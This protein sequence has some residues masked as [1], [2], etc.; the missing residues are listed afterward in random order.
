MPVEPPNPDLA[1]G[2]K[3]ESALYLVSCVSEKRTNAAPA[4]DLYQSDWFVKARA[5]VEAKGGRWF[6][7]SA[8]YGLVSP[9]QVLD[10]Y[11]KT[12]NTMGVAERRN[13]AKKVEQQLDKLLPP[14]DR[15]V[16]LAGERYREFLMPYLSSH[17]TVEVPMK[18]LRIGE[19]LSWLTR[20]H[21]REPRS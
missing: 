17:A 2:L 11:E 12:L 5:F 6:I 15:I 14:A 21:P 1:R 7:L 20:N 9:D 13:W 8:E 16:V 3:G 10:P 19:Q 4:K 18:G